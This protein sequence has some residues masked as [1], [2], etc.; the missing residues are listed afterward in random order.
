MKLKTTRKQ[1]QEYHRIV[2]I[3]YCEAQF[4]LKGHTPFAYSA[5][6]CGWNADYYDIDGVLIATGYRSMPSS[7]NVKCDYELVRKFDNEAISM[8]PDQAREHARKFIAKIIE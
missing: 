6:V 2:S 4:L 5:G 1:M 7:K 8:S 3:G